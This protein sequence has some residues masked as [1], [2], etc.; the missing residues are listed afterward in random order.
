MILTFVCVAQH[1]L[2]IFQDLADGYDRE[3]YGACKYRSLPTSHDADN[4]DESHG[5]H[6]LRRRADCRASIHLAG[7]LPPRALDGTAVRAAGAYRERRP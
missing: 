3:H 7:L 6:T 5:P 4:H 1:I 2:A